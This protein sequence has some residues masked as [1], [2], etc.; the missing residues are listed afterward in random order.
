MDA[1][2]IFT[3]LPDRDSALSLALNSSRRALRRA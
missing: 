3:N 1:I 2:L